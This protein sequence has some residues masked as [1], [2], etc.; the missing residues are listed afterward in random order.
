M[1]KFYTI[2]KMY[3]LHFELPTKYQFDILKFHI[4]S[5]GIFTFGK[6]NFDIVTLYLQNADTF[7]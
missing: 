6:S 4:L 3:P 1:A 2:D 5:F 7:G